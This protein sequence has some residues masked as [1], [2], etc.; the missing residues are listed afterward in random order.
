[1]GIL[2]EQKYMELLSR[3]KEKKYCYPAINVTSSSTVI[4]ALNGLA[5]AN[6]DGII[7]ITTGGAKSFAGGG[8]LIDGAIGFAKYIHEIAKSYP[9]NVALHTDHSPKKNLN[10]FIIPLFNYGTESVRRGGKHL[11]QSHMWDG[12]ALSLQE[13]LKISKQLLLKSKEIGCLLEI[14]IGA[15][16]GEEDGIKASKDA[17]LYSSG[18]DVVE[19][20]KQLGTD[21]DLYIVAATFGN[22]HGLYKPGNVKLRPKILGE[23]QDSVRKFVKSDKALPLNLVF[24]GG[25]GSN[26]EEIRE[27]IDYG[28]VK[29]NVDTELQ[30]AFTRKIADHMLSNYD[31]VLSVDQKLA[32]KK[33]YDPRSYTKAAQESMSNK[34]VEICK[35][36]RCI[37]SHI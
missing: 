37:D 10:D 2:S 36:L 12:S 23:I 11:F 30:Y 28:V 26:T 18:D 27:A 1:M 33:Y 22:V 21:F 3:A 16:G 24:H 14:E 17:K 7:Q 9:I 15:V 19:A 25:S 8:S 35:K 32:T 4:G 31:K 5:E 6:S 29:F 20:V 34:I 13:N